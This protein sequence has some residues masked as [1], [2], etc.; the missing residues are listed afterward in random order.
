MENQHTKTREQ[1]KYS[2]RDKI[3]GTVNYLAT[4]LSGADGLFCLHGHPTVE[5]ALKSREGF[6]N[7][8]YCSRIFAQ[9]LKGI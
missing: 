2:L 8:V 3:T 6:I 1:E 5:D 7:E 9:E 4:L